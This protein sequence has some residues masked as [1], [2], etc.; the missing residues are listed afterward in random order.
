MK[1]A[2]I[3]IKVHLYCLFNT[4]PCDV[5]AMEITVS[6]MPHSSLIYTTEN[7]PFPPAGRTALLLLGEAVQH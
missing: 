2:V 6:V 4:L 1:S 7:G 5:V 3:I